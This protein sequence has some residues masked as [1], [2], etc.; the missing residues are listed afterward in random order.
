MEREADEAFPDFDQ[1]RIVHPDSSYRLFLALENNSDGMGGWKVIDTF[2]R[3]WIDLPDALRAD[4]M[5]WRW[6]KGIGERLRAKMK[7]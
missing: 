1:I 3:P 2:G 4:L 7:D 6:L 5:E